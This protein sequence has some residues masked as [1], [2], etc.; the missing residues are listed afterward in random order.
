MAVVS[1]AAG[2]CRSGRTRLYARGIWP[3]QPLRLHILIDGLATGGAQNLL[4]SLATGAAEAEIELS[5]THLKDRTEAAGLLREQGIEP[6]FVEVGSLFTWRGRRRLQ[7]HLAAAQPDLVHTNLGRADYVGGL[8]A[9]SLGIPAVSTLHQAEWSGGDRRER[10]RERLQAHVRR[11]C[12]SRVIAVSEAARRV[13]LAHGWDRPDRVV[14]VENGIADQAQ[15]GGPGVREEL[16]IATGDLVLTMLGTLRRDK[17]H[18]AAAGA[19]RELSRRFPNLRLLV[20]G[21]GPDRAEIEALL[22]DLGSSAI[23][24]G[25]RHDVAAV[26]NASDVLVHP[27]RMEAFPTALLEAMAAGVPCVATAVGGV[28]EI[29]RDGETGFLVEPPASG[30]DLAAAI[31]PLLADAATRRRLGDA[32]RRLFEQRFTLSHW[33]DRLLPVYEAALD[34]RQPALSR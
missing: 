10:V 32:G 24:A 26:L 21:D 15:A 1:G 23:L 8:A 18:A 12:D 25:E 14:A 28:P 5:V 16:G 29:V 17:G 11:T 7:R 4:A 30:D 2:S 13:Y 33:M 9:R 31:G 20:L 19:V 22:R 3:R 34:P 27:S 6:T